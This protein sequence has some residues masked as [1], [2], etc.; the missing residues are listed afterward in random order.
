MTQDAPGNAK[1]PQHIS[2]ELTADSARVTNLSLRG[3]RLMLTIEAELADSQL[4]AGG[5]P[6]VSAPAQPQPSAAPQSMRPPPDEL[7]TAWDLAVPGDLDETQV[8]DPVVPA[9]DGS[10]TGDSSEDVISNLAEEESASSNRLRR[11]TEI[12]EAI[13]DLVSDAETA[14]P[15]EPMAA[16]DES[17]VASIPLNPAFQ[18]EETA[19]DIRA[20]ETEPDDQGGSGSSP[21]EQMTAQNPWRECTPPP[22][23]VPPEEPKAACGNPETAGERQPSGMN[24]D[25]AP[26]QAP[27]QA[28]EPIASQPDRPEELETAWDIAYDENQ[29]VEAGETPSALFSLLRAEQES[30]SDDLPAIM[31]ES[32]AVGGERHGEPQPAISFGVAPEALAPEPGPAV[33][34]PVQSAQPEPEP[35]PVPPPPA[36]PEQEEASIPEPTPEPEPPAPAPEP[37]AAIEPPPLPQP[38]PAPEPQ[39]VPEPHPGVQPEMA[40]PPPLP[41]APEPEPE[42]KAPES[43]GTTVLIRYT[44]PRCKTQGMQ[45]VDKVGSVVNCSNCGK[46]MRLVMKK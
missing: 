35:E 17:V 26:E 24:F 25:Q 30:S 45:A 46:A 3:N 7:E 28:A 32:S 16:D 37:Q 31:D 19:W 13:T 5:E 34:E 1:K 22:A 6:I 4:A 8:L 44:C 12:R 29:A 9:Q 38:E 20:R 41:P 43:G 14:A 2:M 36:M 33:D 27:A 23:V 10:E 11:D 40:S 15:S 39:P 42:E 21:T 18:E